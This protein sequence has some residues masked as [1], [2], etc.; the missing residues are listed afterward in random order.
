MATSGRGMTLAKVEGLSIKVIGF[1]MIG[2][3][4]NNRCSFED[5]P[6]APPADGGTKSVSRAT[7]MLTKNNN[8]LWRT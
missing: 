1:N 2:I 7:I 8:W 3:K 6:T 4:W 5:A